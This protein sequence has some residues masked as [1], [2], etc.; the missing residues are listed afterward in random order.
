MECFFK[1]KKTLNSQFST[2][3][4]KSGQALLVIVLIMVIGLTVGLAVASRSI[5]NV[6]TSTEEE[7][8]QRA[9]S[10]AEAGIEKVLKTGASTS[11]SGLNNNSTFNTTIA[12]VSGTEIILN[13]ANPVPKDEGVDIWLVPHLSNNKPDYANPSCSSPCNANLWIYWGLDP[14]DCNNAAIEIVTIYG[15][16]GAPK[17]SRVAFDPCVSR[18]A[19]N[20]FANPPNGGSSGGKLFKYKSNSITMRDGLIIR[21]V[22]I[23]KNAIIG[24]NTTQALP[25][26]GKKIESTGT[27]GSTQRKI[28][29]IQGYPALPVELFPN[30]LFSPK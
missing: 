28:N 21:V 6:R 30:I 2:L 23:Y 16:V 7:N 24:V 27:S 15:P 19:S 26:Q 29:Y 9:F 10:A 8:S 11:T 20:G 13:G 22:P 1:F 25:S 17:S 18:R 4:S 12:V 14:T 5:I 3:N